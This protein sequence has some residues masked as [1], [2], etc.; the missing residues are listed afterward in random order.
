MLLGEELLMAAGVALASAWGL[1]ISALLKD[2]R[3]CDA[4]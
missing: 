2:Q 4:E 1:F 3:I